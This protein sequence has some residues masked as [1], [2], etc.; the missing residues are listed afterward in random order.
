SLTA[1]DI[2]ITIDTESDYT[3][4]CAVFDY[5]YPKNEFF[6]AGDII[7]LFESKP[8]LK[9]INKDSVRN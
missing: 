7:K 6:N 9:F 2:R 4:L 3:L 5:L 8:W 1:P